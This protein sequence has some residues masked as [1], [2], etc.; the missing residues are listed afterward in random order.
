M[1]DELH[2]PGPWSFVEPGCAVDQTGKYIKLIGGGEQPP[3]QP[4]EQRANANLIAAAPEL[5][6]ALEQALVSLEDSQE[7]VDR[8]ENDG[9]DW[10]IQPKR[11][12]SGDAHAFAV[13]DA[14]AAI[15]KAKGQLQA[16]KEENNK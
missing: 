16:K 14:R 4:K 11:R 9:C 12:P 15:S 10:N 13:R 3:F 5:L 2:T 7:L 8:Y 1:S 6:E